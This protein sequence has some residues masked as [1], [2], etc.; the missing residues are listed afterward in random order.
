[1]DRGHRDKWDQPKSGMRREFGQLSAEDVRTED[2][3][4]EMAGRVVA[5]AGIVAR[6]SIN[7]LP[8]KMIEAIRCAFGRRSHIQKRQ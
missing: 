3:N 2:S 8:T 1:M 6:S 4:D 7:I 5:T